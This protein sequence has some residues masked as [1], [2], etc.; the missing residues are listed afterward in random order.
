MPIGPP[1]RMGACDWPLPLAPAVPC[2]QAHLRRAVPAS[3]AGRVG[4]LADLAEGVVVDPLAHRAGRGVAEVRPASEQAALAGSAKVAFLIGTP[5]RDIQQRGGMATRRCVAMCA[6]IRRC[7]ATQRRV[8]MTRNWRRAG[9][10][11]K[12]RHLQGARE[13]DDAGGLKPAALA[14]PATGVGEIAQR[15]FHSPVDIGQRRAIGRRRRPEGRRIA[16]GRRKHAPGSPRQLFDTLGGYMDSLSLC[17]LQTFISRRTASICSRAY[18][19][20]LPMPGQRR[21]ASSH[22][23]GLSR[24]LG[25]NGH[26]RHWSGRNS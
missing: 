24:L 11:D 21:D 22:A 23:S 4:D 20:P 14:A 5:P 2:C 25:Q 10:G 13:E 18:S 1:V 6:E 15:R 9:L 7:M 3:V 16:P 12:V 8:A 17:L 19:G 26:V